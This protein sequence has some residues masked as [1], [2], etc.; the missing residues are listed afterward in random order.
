LGTRLQ[1]SNPHF[2]SVPVSG[3]P[4]HTAASSNQTS[5]C[6]MPA[7]G[8]PANGECA[9]NRRPTMR[10]VQE[11]VV[12]VLGQ[13]GPAR[14][15]PPHAE[16]PARQLCRRHS[17]ASTVQ[18]TVVKCTVVKCVNRVLP[19]VPFHTCARSARRIAGPTLHSPASQAPQTATKTAWT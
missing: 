9:C 7:S 6:G 1:Q 2:C 4:S 10:E 13:E 15:H 16:V 12:A 18:S 17:A 8:C 19:S 5:K 11:H 3:C 14:R